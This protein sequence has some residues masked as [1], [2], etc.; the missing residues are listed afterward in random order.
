MTHMKSILFAC[1]FTMALGGVLGAESQKLTYVDLVERVS[2]LE[3]LALLPR[4]GE[5]CAQWSSYDRKSRYNDTTGKYE[6]WDANGDGDGI[7]RK[8][9]NQLVIAEMKGPGCIWRI[10][11]ATPGNGHVR[12][13]LDDQKEPVTDLPF[14]GYFDRKNEPFTR[15]TLVHTVARGWNNYTPISYQ[16]NCRIVADPDWG[17][18]YQFVYTTFADGTEVPTF[19]RELNDAEKAALDKVEQALSQCGPADSGGQVVKSKANVA[20][21][22]ESSRLEGPA[23]ITCIKVR[24]TLPGGV[25]DF[26]ALRSAVIQINW[27][28]EKSPSVWSP[29]GDFFG[30]A[31]GANPYASLPAGL[32]KDGWWYCNWFMPFAKSAEVTFRQEGN[33]DK[34]LK[35]ETEIVTKPLSGDLSRY[36]RFHAKWHRDVFLPEAKERAIDWTVVKAEGSGRFVGMM[37]HVWNPR[38]S[39]WGEG[40]E[41]FFVDGEK[42]PSTIGTGSEDY[43]GY[44]WCNPSLF[45]NAFHNQTRNDG[46]NKGHV[47]LNR[48]HVADNVPFQKSFEGSIE[49][50]FSNQR[51]T[52]YAA[53]AYWYLAADGKDPYQP[54]PAAQRIGY[55][56]PIETF[57]VKNSVEGEALKILRKTAGDPQEQDMTGFE[58]QW[59][60]DAHLWWVQAKQGDKLDLAL[61][62]AKAGKYRLTCQLTKAPDYGIVQFYLDGQKLGEPKDLY[63]KNV[64]PTG[65]IDFG[66]RDLKQGDHVL[67]VEIVGANPK[68]IKSYMFGLDYFRLEPQS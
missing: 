37:L 52:L 35:L 47:S 43:F 58:G 13:Y 50:Y 66:A 40:D 64:I 60:N 8:Q 33:P 34:A 67:Q 49:K 15:P 16:K 51:P 41:K 39:W 9:G 27:D 55:W 7:I 23:A 45:Q 31:P 21:T 57:K 68:A 32:T 44:A 19:K 5:T 63:H 2:S 62:V 54:V 30:T 56:T 42:F 11:S 53:T 24:A 14:V 36:G 18:Y 6:G 22:V 25:A 3:H 12:V 1:S 65:P 20:G 29:L 4:K 59:S 28:G 38:G 46:N 48:W 10:W 17:A 26:D 61:P